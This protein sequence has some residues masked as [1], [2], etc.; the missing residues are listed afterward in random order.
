MQVNYAVQHSS[1][2]AWDGSAAAPIDIR[3][4][5]GFT[6]SFE[7]MQDLANDT[8]FNVMSVRIRPKDP[9]LVIS[10]V[11]PP[12]GIVQR[13]SAWVWADTMTLMEGSRRSAQRG[14]WPVAERPPVRPAGSLT[15]P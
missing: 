12:D 8:I 10:R 7:V 13:Y 11:A 5:V 4:F 15:G 1:K 9:A 3:N 2:L 6:F 14:T